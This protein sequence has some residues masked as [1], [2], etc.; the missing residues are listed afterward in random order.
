MLNSIKKRA[1]RYNSM[2]CYF[3]TQ[4]LYSPSVFERSE[5]VNGRK[6]PIPLTTVIKKSALE[7][8]FKVL[9]KVYF[10]VYFKAH[11]KV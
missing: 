7:V 1:I 5:L 6:Y 4:A 10:K 11:F 8:H 9:F 2:K 3:T